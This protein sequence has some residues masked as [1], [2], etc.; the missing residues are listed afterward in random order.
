MEQMLV[1]TTENNLILYTVSPV[2]FSS[3]NSQEEL[4]LQ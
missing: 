4:N 1:C 2:D 3:V